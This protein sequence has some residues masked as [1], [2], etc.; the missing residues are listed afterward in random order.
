MISPTNRDASRLSPQ[1]R[2]TDRSKYL[3]ECA[4]VDTNNQTA[5]SRP[6]QTT[7][8]LLHSRCELVILVTE[9]IDHGV[10]DSG[11]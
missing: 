11:E 7:H 5:A 8:H 6:E 9:N 2:R 1:K 4:L 10:A 3:R